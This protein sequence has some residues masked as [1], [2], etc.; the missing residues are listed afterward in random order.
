MKL[1][2][3]LVVVCTVTCGLFS[4]LVAP[5]MAVATFLGMAAPLA[6]GLATILLVEHTTRT[7]MR[8]LTGRMTL[9]FLAKMV[10]YALYV[11]LVIGVLGTDPLPFT[12]SFTLYFVALQVTE[13]LYFKNLFAKTAANATVG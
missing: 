12:I 9:A 7:D 6:T 13:A 8:R 4:T 1:A 5:D 11:S 10:F 2:G 3:I